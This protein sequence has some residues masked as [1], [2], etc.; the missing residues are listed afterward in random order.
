MIFKVGVSTQGALEVKSVN[1][2]LNLH[3]SFYSFEVHIDRNP[4][5]GAGS[6]RSCAKYF[7][8]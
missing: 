8:F 6:H 3:I 5:E 1:I 7:N 4:S 2:G